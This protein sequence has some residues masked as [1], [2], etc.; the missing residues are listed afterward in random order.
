MTYNAKVTLKFDST[1]SS[2]TGG[3]YDAEILPEQHITF[4]APAEDLN[5]TQLF[6]LFSKFM[7]SLGYTEKSIA[8]GACY[9]AFNDMRSPEDMKK[10]ADEYDL[11]LAEDYHKKL[12]EYDAQQ[13]RDIA[14]LEVEIRELKEKL[15]KFLPEQYGKVDAPSH[16]KSWGKLVPGSP[17]AVANSCKCPILDNEEMPDDKKWVNENCPLHG[18]RT[19]Q[20]PTR[21]PIILSYTPETLMNY[22]PEQISQIVLKVLK[23]V[24]EPDVLALPLDE[25]YE[26]AHNP[27]TPVELLKILATDKY[28][29]VRYWVAKHPNTH[30]ETLKVLATYNHYSVRSWVAKHPNTP[31]EI[32]KVLATDENWN[33]RSGVAQNPNTPVETLKVLATDEDYS[34]RCWVAVNPN[35]PVEILKVLATDKNYAV[36]SWV[37]KHPNY[38][39]KTLELT[40]VQYD[41]LKVLLESSQV[42]SLK[43]LTL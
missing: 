35:T 15:A 7:F 13:D 34:V 6:Q 4:E 32:L 11:I 10:V 39:T 31:V 3:I 29:W 9:L 1:W 8:S 33:V 22:T 16:Y 30:V 24:N 2:T 28:S 42:E 27:N 14:G 19:S 43:T 40:Q 17:E 5:A 18:T 21:C 41:A 12:V 25:K 23:E 36:R 37:A 26:L 38:K 20:S